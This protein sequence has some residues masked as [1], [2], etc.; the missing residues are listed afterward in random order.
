[1][2]IRLKVSNK[3]TAKWGKGRDAN[4]GMPNRLRSWVSGERFLVST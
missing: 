3:L 1:M 2:T 4:I